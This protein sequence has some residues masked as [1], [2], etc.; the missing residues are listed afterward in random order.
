MYQCWTCCQI[1]V[2]NHGQPSCWP[3]SLPRLSHSIWWDSERLS[4]V[5]CLKTFY[6]EIACLTKM[7]FI[8]NH[9]AIKC[10]GV[11]LLSH[12]QSCEPNF[13]PTSI[14][15]VHH[16]MSLVWNDDQK[17]AWCN[18][19]SI[20]FFSFHRSW[21]VLVTGRDLMQGKIYVLL[22]TRQDTEEQSFKTNLHTVSMSICC[23]CSLPGFFEVLIS[24][25]HFWC[26]PGWYLI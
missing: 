23:P 19:F 10:N 16:T 8:R 6:W 25:W 11:K 9:G 17:S 15:S 4:H 12:F 18:W 1:I 26:Q 22:A 21:V 24:F 7:T 13:T 20:S 5:F 2:M 3:S 14:A